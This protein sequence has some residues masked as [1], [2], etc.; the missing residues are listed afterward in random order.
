MSKIKKYQ[1]KRDFAKTPEPKG[2]LKKTR[3]KSIFVV[4]E[5]DARRD[6]FDFRLEVENVLKSWAV[7]KGIPIQPAEKHLAVETEDHPVEYAKFE[8]TIPEGQY[9]AGT[10][11]IW[12]KG[13]F[14]QKAWEENKIEFTLDGKK[15]KGRYVLVRLKRAGEKSWLLLKGR[16]E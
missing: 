5:H 11:K 9:G 1:E 14:E 4:Q 3:K 15:L 2:K 13:K 16:Q 7:P 12:D 8:G 6:H 10:V